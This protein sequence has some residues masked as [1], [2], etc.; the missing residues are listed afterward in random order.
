MD[1]AELR[2]RIAQTR[3]DVR[4]WRLGRHNRRRAD[5]LTALVTE[6]L[7]AEYDVTGDHDAWPLIGTA[8]LSRAT[9]QPCATC[10]TQHGA[11]NRST[12]PR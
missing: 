2:A 7:P 9:M 6:R 5:A 3:C 1:Q 11:A 10:L 8:L 4:R 12:P